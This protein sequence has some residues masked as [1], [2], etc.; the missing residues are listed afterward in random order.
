[1]PT[2][3]ANCG[4][5]NNNNNNNNNFDY[6]ND[7]VVVDG[8]YIRIYLQQAGWAVRRPKQFLNALLQQFISES[9]NSCKQ[10]QQKSDDINAIH[11]NNNKYK[12]SKE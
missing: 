1:M 10:E 3:S 5:S 2:K 7:E 4:D 8:V 9:N 12:D 11:D 6:A